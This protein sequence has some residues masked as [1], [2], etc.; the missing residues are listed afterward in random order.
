LLG[1]KGGRDTSTQHLWLYFK[2][3]KSLVILAK[4]LKGKPTKA[5]VD[6]LN[7]GPISIQQQG[8]NF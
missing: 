1:K 5:R 3:G 7:G 4:L 2:Y 6:N 8:I